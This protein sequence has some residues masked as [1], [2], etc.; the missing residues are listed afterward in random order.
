MPAT[1][2][3]N[4]RINPVLKA[5]GDSALAEIGL[6]PSQA[7]RAL[8]E[9][10]AKRGQ[11]LEEVAQLLLSKGKTQPAHGDLV[12][13]GWHTMDAAMASL[14]LDPAASPTASDDELLEEYWSE[15]MAERSL[16]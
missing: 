11:D 4:T 5:Q 3:M 1:T 13:E 2:Q 16:A 8:W 9:K 10:A 7:I 12:E 15:R 14:G 6:S